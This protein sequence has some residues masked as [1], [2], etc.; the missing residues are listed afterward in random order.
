MTVILLTLRTGDTLFASA[1]E[2]YDLLSEPYAKFLEGLTGNFAPP[3][4]DP[5]SIVDRMWKGHRGSP[6]NTGASLR[7]T[8]PCVRTNPVTGWKA[9]YAMGH[10][11]ESINGLADVETKLVI[12]HLESLITQN[13]HLQVR[14]I[15][16]YICY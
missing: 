1:Y 10:H 16:D 4:H 5:A 8:H 11:L 2:V 15:D 3:H 6:A 9:V 12:K 7:A 14:E 13:H